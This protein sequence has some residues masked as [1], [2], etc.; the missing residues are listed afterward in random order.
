M[1]TLKVSHTMKY[2][3]KCY[4]FFT[5]L[6]ETNFLDCPKFFIVTISLNTAHAST[7]MKQNLLH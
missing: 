3:T 2:F 5:N 1:V 6:Y 4:F 7:E